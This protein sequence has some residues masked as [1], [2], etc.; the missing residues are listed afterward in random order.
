MGWLT[1]FRR[2]SVSKAAGF[3]SAPMAVPFWGGR[4]SR[5]LGGDR[6][7]GGWQRAIRVSNDDALRHSALWACVTQISS[8][9]AKLR[10]CLKQL[11]GVGGYWQE[12]TS[13]AFS[14]VLAQPNS[15]QTPQQFYENWVLCKLIH[16]NT[17]ALK[18]RDGRNIVQALYL[19]DPA[20]VLP[21]VSTDGSAQVFYQISRLGAD[22]LPDVDGPSIYPGYEG[23]IVV[24]SREIIHDRAAVIHHPLC[25]VPPLYA[26]QIA[27]ATG[28]AIGN[29]NGRFFRNGANLSGVLSGPGQIDPDTAKRLSEKW[30]EDFS[31]ESNAGKIAVLGSG[32]K[33]ESMQSNLVDAQVAE[34][35]K[36]SSTDICTAFGVPA[37]KLS[38]D[39]W[40]R[41]L[42]NIQAL[43]I[44]Y[45]EGC[46]QRYITAIEQLLTAGLNLPSG[47]KVALDEAELLRLDSISL[48]TYLSGLV[49]GGLLTPNEGRAKLGLPPVPGGETPYLQQ[50]NWPLSSL[51]ARGVAPSGTTTP[52]PSQGE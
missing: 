26:S 49:L 17:Y 40:P 31:G 42:V 29:S 20:R 36:L 11:S 7:T 19:I 8:D 14:P 10:P 50:Q 45:L 24:P 9:V 16:G 28:L 2:R 51:A 6:D 44:T 34:L 37:W 30:E 1:P 15:Y 38:L 33:F 22:L 21:L 27:V 25:G 18:L 35:A 4:W 12:T 32:L 23:S 46:L 5:L 3:G 47:M 52:P 13:P 48:G 39:Q 43:Q 41:G